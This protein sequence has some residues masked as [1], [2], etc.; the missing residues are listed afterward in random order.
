MREDGRRPWSWRPILDP[1]FHWN[2]TAA[3]PTAPIHTDLLP[4]VI[5]ARQHQ[6]PSQL[7]RAVRDGRREWLH[8]RHPMY[9]RRACTVQEV[10]PRVDDLVCHPV[11][12]RFNLLRDGPCL[13]LAT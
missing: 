7:R 10:E 8:L 6:P 5:S 11:Q 12:I 13:A 3:P 4:L 1:D 9:D 2:H